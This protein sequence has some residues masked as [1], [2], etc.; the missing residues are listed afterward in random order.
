MGFGDRMNYEVHPS[1]DL[2]APNGLKMQWTKSEI[3]D[4]L[5]QK[6]DELTNNIDAYDGLVVIFSGHGKHDSIITSN[7]QLISKQKI[8]QH[9]TLEKDQVA[10]RSIPRLFVF[11]CCDGQYYSEAIYKQINEINTKG[12]G[13]KGSD[14]SQTEMINEHDQIQYEYDKVSHWRQNENNPDHNLVV[15]HAANRGFQA[16]A[17]G[18]VGSYLIHF[19]TKLVT[20]SV[21]PKCRRRCCGPEYLGEIIQEIQNHLERKEK[22]LVVPFYLNGTER[23]AFRPKSKVSLALKHNDILYSSDINLDP[24]LYDEKVNLVE[25]QC[26]AESIRNISVISEN[27]EKELQIVS[28]EVT[29]T[30]QSMEYSAESGTEPFDGAESVNNQSKK[31]GMVAL[32]VNAIEAKQ[33]VNKDLERQNSSERQ[34]IAELVAKLKK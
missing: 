30:E 33:I 4:L 22:Q 26:T 16:N 15:I 10:V 27:E 11:D 14:E 32:H 2:T 18:K 25:M 7:G 28:A 17:D 6:S 31:P 1:Y 8:Y 13:G 9:F 5:N 3:E 23:I 20:A 24:D 21:N 12:N 34:A 29:E 19:L